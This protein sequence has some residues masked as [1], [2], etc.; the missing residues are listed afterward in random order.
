MRTMKLMTDKKTFSIAGKLLICLVVPIIF[1]II[2]GTSSYRRTARYMTENYIS[3]TRETLDMVSENISMRNDYVS[4]EASKY[5]FDGDLNSLYLGTLDSDKVKKA[6]I[7]ADTRSEIMSSVQSN[8]YIENIYIIPNE[9]YEILTTKSTG[10]VGDRL[11]DGCAKEY[12]EDAEHKG[13]VLTRWTDRHD[14]LDKKLFIDSEKSILTYQLYSSN[15]MFIVCYDVK[16]DEVRRILNK[17][18]LGEGSIVGMVTKHG[19]EITSFE[20]EEEEENTV[21]PVFADKDFYLKDSEDTS[22]TNGSAEVTYN[23]KKYLYVFS[24]VTNAN[25]VICA[26]IPMKTITGQAMSVRFFTA[27]LVII[28]SILSLGLGLWMIHLIQRNVQSITKNLTQ[29]AGG[30]L[31]VKVNSYGNDEFSILA[32]ST[33]EM[34]TN[35]RNLVD[36][37]NLASDMLDRTSG[38]VKDTSDAINAY[39]A[40]VQTA[41]TGIRDSMSEQSRYA[42]ECVERTNQLAEEMN[43]VGRVIAEVETLIKKT[44]ALIDN[45]KEKVNRLGESA[46]ETNDITAHVTESVDVLKKETDSIYSFVETITEISEE[47]N[48]L[49]L[50]ASIE[51]ARAG[52]SG[53]GFA[54]V[55][56]AIRKLAENSAVAANEIKNSVEMIANQ[57][58]DTVLSAKKAGT[59]VSAQSGLVDTMIEIFGDMEVQMQSL[60]TGLSNIVES[61]DRANREKDETIAFIQNISALIQESGAC[62]Q[63]VDAV[64]T[65]LMADVEHLDDVS[66]TLNSNMNELKTEISHFKID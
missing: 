5:A 24:K 25:A 51:A 2:I 11:L 21:G 56:E 10:M 45:A 26:L 57:T 14:Y 16:T 59:M 46:K 54:V 44:G 40:N 9:G 1:M 53:R 58:N 3:S 12:F 30:N 20:S 22:M 33:T 48:L 4:T 27:I 49:S 66:R 47:T 43:E 32:D 61:A 17:V 8:D 50:N 35:T 65:L 64:M 29:V 6:A 39:S 63:N 62:A 38:E 7:V 18:D 55:A 23:G 42:G 41:V 31:T 28:S 13:K 15:K 19:R 37:V 36:K 60:V 52:E 34:I